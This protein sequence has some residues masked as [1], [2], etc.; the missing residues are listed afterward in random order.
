MTID[1]LS[2]LMD[3]GWVFLGGWIV[4]LVWVGFISFGHDF[5]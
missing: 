5:L 2:Y 3:S 4:L 1:V